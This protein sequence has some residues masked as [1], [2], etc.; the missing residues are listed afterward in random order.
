MSDYSM[1]F[2]Q[3]DIFPAPILG[4]DESHPNLVLI[5]GDENKLIATM[6]Y[7]VN[8]EPLTLLYSHGNGT[9]IGHIDR[10]LSKLAYCIGM[11][12][13]SYDYPGYGLSTGSLGLNTNNSENQ[14]YSTIRH[15]INYL[16]EKGCKYSDIIL[17][18]SSIGTGPTI[19]LAAKING[20]KCV[21]LQ[22]P[23]TKILVTETGEMIFENEKK[24]NSIDSQ[25]IILHGT[26]DQIVP[27][28]HGIT[29]YNILKDKQKDVKLITI[30]GASHNNIESDHFDIIVS[31][32][33]DFP[34]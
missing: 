25:I 12:I 5:K 14:C 11:N 16:L 28:S 34:L 26:E 9:D 20:L 33:N 19:D 8:D 1:N 17:F 23:F 29:L 22:T 32:I 24:I 15:V 4:Y 2:S 13:I 10:F 31:T 18:G 6:Y 7:K 27:L 21:I 30:C 3:I